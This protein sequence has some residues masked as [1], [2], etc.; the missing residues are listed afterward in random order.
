MRC[1]T[2]LLP[3]LLVL[4]VLTACTGEQGNTATG[5]PGA[6]TPPNRDGAA[7]PVGS[8]PD[9]DFLQEQI[10]VAEKEVGLARLAPKRATR[11]ALREFADRL[12]RDHQQAADE[13]RQIAGRQKVDALA[14]NEQLKTEGER[15]SRLS[16]HEFEREFLDEII[17]DL[18]DAVGD[19]EGAGKTHNSETREWATKTLP[20]VRRQLEEARK[21]RNSVRQRG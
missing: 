4:S 17:A 15:L 18:E 9:T 13:L 8:T 16:G 14:E 7:T 12:A 5:Q 10:A 21:L 2:R 20:T 3:S 1:T 19:L 6:G 11:P